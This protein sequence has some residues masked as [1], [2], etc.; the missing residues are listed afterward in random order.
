[1][2]PPKG[3]TER[4]RAENLP[5]RQS[6]PPFPCGRTAPPPLT[7]LLRGLRLLLAAG[8]GLW[9]LLLRPLRW[10]FFLFLLL[11][12]R[13]QG[14]LGGAAHGGLALGGLLG[15]SATPN[16][17]LQVVL[18]AGQSRRGAQ[19]KNSMA[20]AACVAGMHA[21]L[22]C[23][24]SGQRLHWVSS[25]RY[26]RAGPALRPRARGRATGCQWARQRGA[27]GMVMAARY[28]VEDAAPTYYR[29]GDARRTCGR[30][31]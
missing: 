2:A 16:V 21:V 10:R 12:V 6:P 27:A 11:A 31:T 18:A 14:A 24:C 19:A 23:A 9:L 22:C 26:S 25:M 7:G 3:R 13:L 17:I 30:C 15:G 1:M 8:S 28:A 5:Q 29:A 4:H 20:A